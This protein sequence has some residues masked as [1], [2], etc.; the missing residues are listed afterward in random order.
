ME[1]E[2]NKPYPLRSKYDGALFYDEGTD[3]IA[4]GYLIRSL[5]SEGL[6]QYEIGDS[7][8]DKVRAIASWDPLKRS[9]IL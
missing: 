4:T 7:S 3:V 5:R 8:T 1:P 9:W 2:L 6:W